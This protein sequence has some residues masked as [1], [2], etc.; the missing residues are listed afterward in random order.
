MRRPVGSGGPWGYAEKPEVLAD[1]THEYR[2]HALAAWS[3]DHDSYA[4]PDLDLIHIDFA[5]LAKK[6]ALRLRK[7]K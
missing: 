3:D 2:E 4:Q 5:T 6:W 7:A 1:P